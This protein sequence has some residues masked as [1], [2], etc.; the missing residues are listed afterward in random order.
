MVDELL[1]QRIKHL[2]DDEPYLGYR[3][4]WA[5]LRMA[6]HVVNRKAVQRI[7]QLKCWQYHRR[8]KRRCS[9]R[10]QTSI[11][12]SRVSNVRWATDATY[13]WRV[14]LRR[15]RVRRLEH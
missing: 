5:R 14:G 15:A 13:I 2:I 11:S 6:G 9:P 4:V 1:A 12:V 10:V 3:M 7:M 8:L